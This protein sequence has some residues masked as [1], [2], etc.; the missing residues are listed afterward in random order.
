MCKMLTDGTCRSCVNTSEASFCVQAPTS[1]F[2]GATGT[3]PMVMTG[4]PKGN[5]DPL[6][7]SD[8][9]LPLGSSAHEVGLHGRLLQTLPAI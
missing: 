9:Y 7:R 8:V 5:A 3:T 1:K 6:G 2:S 4:K